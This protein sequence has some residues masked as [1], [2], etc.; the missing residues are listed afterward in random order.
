MFGHW[1]YQYAPGVYSIRTVEDCER[2]IREIFT[3]KTVMND[4]LLRLFLKALESVL[5]PGVVDPYL[6][7]SS[8]VSEEITVDAVSRVLAEKLRKYIPA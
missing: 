7:Q 8:R 1:F 2:A 4:R 6:F 5:V 3:G